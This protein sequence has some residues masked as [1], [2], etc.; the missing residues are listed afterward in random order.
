MFSMLID[1]EFDVKE[2]LENDLVREILILIVFSVYV[3]LY[4]KMVYLEKLYLNNLLVI[5]FFKDD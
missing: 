4:F 1:I 5:I 3:I 2:K